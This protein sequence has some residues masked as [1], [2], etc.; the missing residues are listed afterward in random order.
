MS[1]ATEML[2]HMEHAGHGG[3]HGDGHGKPGPGKQ[4]GITMALLGVMLAFCAAMVGSART[5]LIKATVEQSNKWG[6]YQ[7]ESTKYRVMEAD[8]EMLH[9]LTPSKAELRKFE[10]KLAEVKRPGGK[11][12]DE[13]T[14]ELKQAIHVATTELADVLTPD[15]EDEDR[16]S[17]IARKYKH[18]MAEAKEDAEAYDGAIEAHHESAEHYEWAQ[19]CAEIGIVIA[20]IALLLASRPIW[21]VSVLFGLSG[22]GIIVW[23]FM[24]TR[25]AL[26]NAEKRIEEA[27]KR[28]AVIEKDDEDEDKGGTEKAGEKP[29]EKAKDG[30]KPGAHVGAGSGGGEK[31]GTG[32]GHP[33][34][35]AK[36]AASAH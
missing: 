28:T 31:K 26:H 27:A 34:E 4:I 21:G 25:T 30:E 11:S 10:D 16:I 33:G 15:K 22:A 5:E 6:V 8:F 13:D 12:D 29:E 20:S 36:G 24:S 14:S 18:D 35:H 23:T 2:E 1:E 7:A 19:L 17:G 9:A 32:G 3:G